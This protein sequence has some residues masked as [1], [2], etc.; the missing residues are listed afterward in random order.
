MQ[1]EI[2]SQCTC[3]RDNVSKLFGARTLFPYLS[4]E[5]SAHNCDLHLKTCTYIIL[6]NGLANEAE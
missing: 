3:G 1:C 6:T 4:I 2:R 5:H